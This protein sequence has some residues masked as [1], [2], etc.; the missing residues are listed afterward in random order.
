MQALDSVAKLDHPAGGESSSDH[1][2]VRLVVMV[3]E[4]GDRP[5]RS[6]EAPQRGGEA[7]YV[8]DL[9]TKPRVGRGVARDR[10]EVRRLGIDAFHEP[11]EAPRGHPTGHVEVTYMGD[12]VPVELQGESGQVERD[13]D[14]LYVLGLDLTGVVLVLARLEGRLAPLRRPVSGK[15]PT[16]QP[17]E[18]IAYSYHGTRFVF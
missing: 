1:S 16:A 2:S 9:R 13:W 11:Q 18:G 5:V 12:P 7:G 6:A 17:P 14:D 10:Y 15:K 3:A 8:A 4:D